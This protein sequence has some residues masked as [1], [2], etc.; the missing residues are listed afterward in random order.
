MACVEWGKVARYIV[1]GRGPLRRLG[2]VSCNKG[3]ASTASIALGDGFWLHVAAAAAAFANAM[4][5]SIASAAGAAN[6]RILFIIDLPIQGSNFGSSVL[7]ST[8]ARLPIYDM[9]ITSF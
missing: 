9:S 6:V 7:R 8:L 5:P 1:A 2:A 4:A 3:S